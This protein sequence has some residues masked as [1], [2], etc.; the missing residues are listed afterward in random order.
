MSLIFY[1]LL[2]GFMVESGITTV[3]QCATNE[4]KYREKTWRLRYALHV[5]AWL[6]M[7]VYQRQI[8]TS[9]LRR[10][11]YTYYVIGSQN[12]FLKDHPPGSTRWSVFIPSSFS[13]LHY[14]FICIGEGEMTVFFFPFSVSVYEKLLSEQLRW[15]I[16]PTN[17]TV[18]LVDYAQLL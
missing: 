12:W 8:I 5:S 2:H 13:A 9:V 14:N 11:Y 10:K 16:Y 1:E 15:F 4:L 17:Y 18:Q 3:E 6:L 7:P